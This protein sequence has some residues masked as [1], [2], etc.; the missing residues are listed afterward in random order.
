MKDWE[1]C[2]IVSGA[3]GPVWFFREDSSM[4]TKDIIFKLRTAGGLSQEGLAEMVYTSVEE[5]ID[6]C[7]EHMSNESWPPEQ[8]RSYGSCGAGSEALEQKYEIEM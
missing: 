2:R 7:T 4:E 1:G 6:F 5:L 8:V 3:S